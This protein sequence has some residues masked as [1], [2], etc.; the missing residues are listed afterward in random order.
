MVTSEDVVAF[1]RE[2][3]GRPLSLRGLR[4]SISPFLLP[5]LGLPSSPSSNELR[6]L[7]KSARAPC[8]RA[9]RPPRG[10]GALL[11]L[12]AFVVCSLGLC[13]DTSSTQTQLSVRIQQ[14]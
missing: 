12:E 10:L 2:A 3:Q 11:P 1:V 6:S 9:Q 14:K 8:A 4:V 7:K 5:A 13:K